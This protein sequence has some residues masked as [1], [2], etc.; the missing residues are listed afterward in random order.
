MRGEVKTVFDNKRLDD[1]LSQC[2]KANDSELFLRNSCDSLPRKE[3]KDFS[4]DGHTCFDSALKTN[5]IPNLM[6]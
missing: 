5:L 2:Q 3:I 1:C 6:F 4:C